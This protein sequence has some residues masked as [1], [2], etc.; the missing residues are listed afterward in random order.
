MVS[1][2][3]SHMVSH[4]NVTRVPEN[5][6]PFLGSGGTRQAHNARTRM[7]KKKKNDEDNNNNNKTEQTI[8]QA[9]KL[10]SYS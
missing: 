4:N 1:H 6:K 3:P 7:P 8:K 9:K 2:M 5:Q 10:H